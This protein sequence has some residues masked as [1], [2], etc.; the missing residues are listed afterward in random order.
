MLDQAE[1]IGLG[2]SDFVEGDASLSGRLKVVDHS[3]SINPF[4]LGVAF[5]SH[6]GVTSVVSRDQESNRRSA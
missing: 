4:P 6:D 1:R 3:V 5:A 2:I